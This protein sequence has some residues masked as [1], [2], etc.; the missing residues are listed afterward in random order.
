MRKLIIMGAGGR[1]FHNFNLAFRDDPDTEVVA[2]TAAQIPGIDDRLYPPALSGPRYP[3][4]IPVRPESEI[5]ALVREHEVDEVVFAYS[6]VSHEEVMHH[7]SVAIAA[8]ADF[9]LMGGRSA[10]LSSARPVVAV[11]AV[12]TGCG[13]S[14]TSREVGRILLAA[15][16]DVALV[17]HPMPYHDLAAIAVQRFATLEDI[18]ASNPTIEEREEYERPVEMGMVMYAGVDYGAILE[19]AQEEADVIIWDGGNNDFSFYRADLTIVVVDPLRPGHALRYHP[20]EA[21]LRM[22]D[23]VVVNKVDSA[24]PEQMAAVLEDVAQ[25]APTAT[26]IHAASPVVLEPGPPLA[27]KRVLVIDDGPTITHGGMPFGAGAVAARDAGAIEVDPRPHAVGSI[28]ETLARFPH[29]GRVVPAMGY[30]DE[31]LGDLERTINAV[32]CDAVIAGTPIDL[33]RLVDSRHP[34]RRV[35]YSLQEVGESRLADVLAPIIDRAR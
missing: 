2:F 23:V 33:P 6:D 29:I 1:D 12:R 9:R 19:Q 31:Q 22:A 27:G 11:C 34:I 17:R 14:Q 24:T 5:A 7:A 3:E 15:G 10:M 20:G 21:N 28:A 35:T 25:L 18:D 8:G 32:D 30:S 13:K 4:G 26:V 16:L